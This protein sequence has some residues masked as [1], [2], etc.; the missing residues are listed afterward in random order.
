M[1]RALSA[2]ALALLLLSPAL[3]HAAPAAA[4]QPAQAT[5][6]QATAP[7]TA[8]VAPTKRLSKAEWAALTP[9]QKKAI[10]DARKKAR[11]AKFNSLSPAEQQAVLKK[12]EER[13]L[14]MK[15]KREELQKKIAAMTPDQRAAF[16]KDRQAKR[17]A[18]KKAQ[19]LATTLPKAAPQKTT[20]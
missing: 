4:S 15:V 14:Q 9:D 10:R 18:R 3:V 19:S 7:H 13:M 16:E 20:P 8:T 6:P 2:A 5:V 1:N 11:E 17:D 12:R